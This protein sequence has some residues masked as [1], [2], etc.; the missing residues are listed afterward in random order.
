MALTLN[1]PGVYVEEVNLLP[2][3]VAQVATAIPAF[4]GYTEK[5][6]ALDGSPLR[7]DLSAPPVPVR[8]TSMLEYQTQFGKAQNQQGI[9]VSVTG[10]SIKPDLLPADRSDFLMYYSMQMYFANGGGP[11][12][13]VSVG[14]YGTPL[15]ATTLKTGLTAIEKEDEPTLL[16]FPDGTSLSADD[17]Y[18]LYND[19]LM[20]CNKLQDRFTIIDTRMNDLTVV[21]TTSDFSDLRNKISSDPDYVKYGA[22][23]YPYLKTTVD[24]QYLDADVEVSITSAA[25]YDG[26]VTE[27]NTNYVDNARVLLAGY[28]TEMGGYQTDAS[29]A[30]TVDDAIEIAEQNVVPKIN[31]IT[32]VSTSLIASLNS[33]VAIADDVI[34]AYPPA[35]TGT[36]STL[37]ANIVTWIANNPATVN[38]NLPADVLVL[39]TL[40]NS[41]DTQT[42][43]ASKIGDAI[44]SLG[45]IATAI[46]ALQSGDIASLIL[47]LGQFSTVTTTMQ[48]DAV[49]ISN[50]GLYNRIVT[51]ISQLPVLLPPSSSV[52]GVYARVDAASGVWKA[53]ANTSLNY[54][55]GPNYNISNDLQDGMNVDTFS[56]KSINA[57]RP[58]TGK[59]TLIWG[60]RTLNGN[61]TEWKY[62]SVRRFY[63]MVEESVK[64]ATEG[65]VFQANDAN[66]WVQVRAMIENFLI[67][68]WKA[69]ALAG[70]KPEQAFY[71]RI[72]L[73]STMTADDVLNGRMI[74]EIG[75]AVVRP[76][77][78]IVLRFSHMM[79]QA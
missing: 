72:G 53:P 78:F 36:V 61:S 73:G 45:N 2:P 58:F 52:A 24:Y 76:A 34:A 4:I 42:T 56:G 75:M 38:A 60:A 37:R 32:T 39:T 25:D 69:G 12:Y 54:V 23:Y 48:L 67:L 35:Q 18:G 57:I 44:T 30:L 7:P 55:I 13:I 20:Q 29:N 17:L 1:T 22:A 66:T 64:K 31:Q 71:V 27:I 26:D 47:E 21:Q 6:L 15:S 5:A 9:T 46:T 16:L 8:I 40:D 14:G 51:S 28:T 43:V 79:Q 41:V 11:C 63:N 62:I 77:E 50:N 65:F 70:A 19:A 33:I 10:N 3:S 68:Q 74:V 59:G 49:K